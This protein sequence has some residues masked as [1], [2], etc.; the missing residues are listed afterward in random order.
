M[1]SSRIIILALASTL[2]L[3]ACG[4][5][6]EGDGSS[7]Q[8]GPNQGGPVAKSPTSESADQTVVLDQALDVYGVEGGVLVS[9]SSLPIGTELAV[10]S[11]Y[12]T[13][14]LNYKDTNGNVQRSSTGFIFPLQIVS[15]PASATAHFPNS[16]IDRLNTTAGGLYISAAIVGNLQG[17]TGVFNILSPATEGSGFLA[18]FQA[19]GQ[20]KYNYLK[21]VTKR[22]GGRLNK[23][24]DP[25]SLSAGDQVKWAKIY[26]ELK[27]F[28]DRSTV[29]TPKSLLMIDLALAKQWS[30]EFESTGAIAPN[31]AWTIA[32]EATAVRHGF[33]NTPCA[34]FMSE[35][36]RESY[37]RAGYRVSDDFN[38]DKDNEL[39]WS[40]SAAVVNF[41]QA[42]YTAGWIPWDTRAYRPVVGALLMNGAGETPGHTFIS[43]G[44]DGRYIVDNG[45]PQGR[46]LRSTSLKIINMMYQPGV[47]FLP[48]GI[49]P[50][51]WTQAP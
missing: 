15:V 16:V 10:P 46:D 13:S 22:F 30:L 39:I 25:N 35:L 14:N 5:P 51:K 23:G 6:F 36:V 41:S 31:G 38:S 49:N 42:L 48:P 33:A 44:D 17:V 50:P 40:N 29:Q 19:T 43:A 20:P 45:S 47:F 26:S 34:E 24:V 27:A 8:N 1:N 12:Q 3:A 2:S 28:A 18:N 32:T 21:S 9:Q 11:N 4:P 37:Q 7:K